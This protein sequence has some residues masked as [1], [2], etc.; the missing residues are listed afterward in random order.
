MR[1]VIANGVFDLLHDGHRHLLREAKKHG[2]YLL[3]LVNNDH[4]ARHLKG[5]GRPVQSLAERMAALQ[6]VPEVDNVRWFADHELRDKLIV[7][8]PDVLVKGD[9]YAYEDVVGADIV[10]QVV[11]VPRLPGFSTTEAIARG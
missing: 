6:A 10:G 1:L 2:D 3:V 9:D 4:S 7:W 8:R 11:L 5:P